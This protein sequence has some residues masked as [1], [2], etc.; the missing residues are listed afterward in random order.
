MQT[1]SVKL[2]QLKAAQM[3]TYLAAALFILGNIMLPQLCH[4]VPAGGVALLYWVQNA[5]IPFT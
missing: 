2:Y 4:T 3:R 5:W 1:T